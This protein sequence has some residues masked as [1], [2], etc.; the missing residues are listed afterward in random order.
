MSI[1]QILL[2]IHITYGGIS[3]V[4]GLIILLGGKGNTRH[5]LMGK[6][7]FFSMLMAAL[8]ALPMSY[9]HPSYFLFIIGVF[10]SYMLLSGKRYLKKKTP[11]NIKPVDWLLTTIMLV[12][13][14]A[15]IGMG[16]YN[17]LQSNFFGVVFI[18]FGSISLIF[19]YQDYI[20]F[21]GRASVKNFWLT[22][23]IQRMVGSYIASVTAFLVVNN[24]LLPGVIAWL[25]PTIVLVPLIIYW[26]RKHEVKLKI[27]PG[28]SKT[29]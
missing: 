10:T 28:P 17:L 5:K 16:I 9:L 21:K 7:Y 11:A 14:A 12:F 3:L 1:F 19:V 18:A 24:T 27:K 25:L 8:I 2:F 29:M 20:N 23:H 4:V 13:G 26:S 22:T 6:I 15:F